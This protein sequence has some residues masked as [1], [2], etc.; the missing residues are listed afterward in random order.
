MG[1][2]RWLNP[3][4]TYVRYDE[5]AQVR[6]AERVYHAKRAADLWK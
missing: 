1:Y 3:F 5:V 6:F 4:P 2:E